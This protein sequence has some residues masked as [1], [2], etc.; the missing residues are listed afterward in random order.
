MGRH[1]RPS[2]QV[3]W[4]LPRETLTALRRPR[5]RSWIRSSRERSVPEVSLGDR[6]HRAEVR[7]HGLALGLRTLA[8]LASAWSRKRRR[9]PRLGAVESPQCLHGRD[10]GER[11]PLG[12]RARHLRVARSPC[13]QLRV[14]HLVSARS[15]ICHAAIRRKGEQIM[16]EGWSALVRAFIASVLVPPAGIRVPVPVSAPFV[17]SASNV[18]G[19]SRSRQLR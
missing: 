12:T 1:C 10:R 2:R 11:D 6:E 5:S 13:R 19:D 7:F 18:P 15:G 8:S 17:K 3:I 9:C 4:P 16:D 14:A